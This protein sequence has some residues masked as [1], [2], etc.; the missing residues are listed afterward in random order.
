MGFHTRRVVRNY[1]VFEVPGFYRQ[2]LIFVIETVSFRGARFFTPFCVAEITFE[3]CGFLT[4]SK[5]RVVNTNLADIC[6]STA[7]VAQ[8]ANTCITRA[9]REHRGQHCKLRAHA[10]TTNGDGVV[11]ING[12]WILL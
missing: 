2:S 8:A 12:A 3:V 9:R 11:I 5:K 4:I 10:F 7:R 6:M 1:L